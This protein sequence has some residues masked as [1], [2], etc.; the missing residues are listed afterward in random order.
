MVCFMNEL[1]NDKSNVKF[2][3]FIPLTLETIFDPVDDTFFKEFLHSDSHI[4]DSFHILSALYSDV[5]S[6]QPATCF[7]FLDDTNDSIQ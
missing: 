6:F 2:S 1:N 7:N 3:I 4:L 5:L